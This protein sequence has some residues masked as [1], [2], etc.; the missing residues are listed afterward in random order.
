L[1]PADPNVR[2]RLERDGA[3]HVRAALGEA[4]LAALERAFA[5][6]PGR[7]GARLGRGLSPLLGKADA[8]AARLLGPAARAVRALLLDKRP[9]RNWS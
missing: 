8:I 9:E 1:S 5:L 4:D 3:E 7:P 6:P 2:V